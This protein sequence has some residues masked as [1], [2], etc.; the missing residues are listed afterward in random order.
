[1]R[2]LGKKEIYWIFLPFTVLQNKRAEQINSRLIS[3]NYNHSFQQ[4]ST[5]FDSI[6]KGNWKLDQDLNDMKME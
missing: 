6:H 4:T 5:Y 2:L 1:M 3:K